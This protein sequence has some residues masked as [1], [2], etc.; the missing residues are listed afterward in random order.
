MTIRAFSCRI[1]II[2]NSRDFM[3]QVKNGT[4][5]ISYDKTADVLYLA[6]GKPKEG[7]DEEVSEGV[8]VRLDERTH[9]AI[10]VTIVDFEKRFSRPVSKS[11]PIDL[12]RFLAP[13]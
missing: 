11:V 8:F 4:L 5:R 7:I 9:R 2:L 1:E 13:A 3:V 10:G 12:A 6:F